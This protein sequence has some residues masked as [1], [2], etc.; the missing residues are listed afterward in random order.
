MLRKI[1]EMMNMTKIHSSAA[2]KRTL[3]I[4]YKSIEQV[5]LFAMVGFSN[6]LRVFSFIELINIKKISVLSIYCTAEH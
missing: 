5:L 2:G 4:V 3:I 1:P 6:T